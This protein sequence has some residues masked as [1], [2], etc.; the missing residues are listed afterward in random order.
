[1]I[2]ICF[3]HADGRTERI[4]KIAPR[5]TRRAAEAYER[6]VRQQ[7]L[8]GTYGHEESLPVPTINAFSEEFLDHAKANNKPSTI[9]HKEMVVRKHIKP[10]FGKKRLDQIGIREAEQFKILKTNQK[11]SPKTVNNLLSVLHQMLVVAGEWKLISEVPIFHFVKVPEPD[12]DFLDFEEAERLIAIN[13]EPEWRTM[14][15]VAMKTGMRLGELRALQFDDL[16]LV[17]GQIV[18]RHSVWKDQM[19]SPKNG[20]NREL[21][22]SEDALRAL[23]AHRHLRGDFV[24]C[25]EDGSMLTK[26]QCKW[27][28]WRACKRAGL[29]KIGWHILRHTFASLLVMRGAPLKSVQ[30]LLGHSTIE[31]TMRYSHL[32]PDLK[33]DVVNLLDSGTI[34]AHDPGSRVNVHANRLESKKI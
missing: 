32:S 13:M 20:R 15:L 26:E 27:P 6:Q 30:E 21:P 33:R 18:V 19:G 31:M 14:I 29:R 34:A 23:K 3:T 9:A 28:L 25:N 12:F 4:R 16:D 24:F 7:L 2:D 8:D 11:L 17:K 1:M 5:Q 22:L 10:L